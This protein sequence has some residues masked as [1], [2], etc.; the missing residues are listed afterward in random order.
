MFNKTLA[1]LKAHT[2]VQRPDLVEEC[3]PSARSHHGDSL[4]NSARPHKG[5]F[6]L[7]YLVLPD[8]GFITCFFYHRQD[9]TTCTRFLVVQAS[10]KHDKLLPCDRKS[11]AGGVV[12]V[13][14]TFVAGH[15]VTTQRGL[16]I[17]QEA[18]DRIPL[19]EERSGLLATPRGSM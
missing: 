9:R 10:G 11:R 7:G 13:Q 5:D 15:D 12:W 14:K 18:V 3:A 6:R 1:H 8:F 4:F 17:D 19:E 16:H 2:L